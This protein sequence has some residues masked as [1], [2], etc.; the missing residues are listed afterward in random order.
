MGAF[1]ERSVLQAAM[2]CLVVQQAPMRQDGTVAYAIR[3]AFT[4]AEAAEPAQHT[5][6]SSSPDIRLPSPPS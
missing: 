1:A 2:A 5:M 4:V 6:V 3:C